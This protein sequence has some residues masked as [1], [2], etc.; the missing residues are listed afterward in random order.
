MVRC[1]CL[2]CLAGSLVGVFLKMLV[3]PE[4]CLVRFQVQPSEASV[5]RSL[6][7]GKDPHWARNSG[8][9]RLIYWLERRGAPVVLGDPLLYLLLYLPLLNGRL[10]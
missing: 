2:F 8:Y 6:D 10:N 9:L 4:I 3:F 5:F 1:L 7:I